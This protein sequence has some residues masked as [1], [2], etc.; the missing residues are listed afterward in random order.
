MYHVQQAV[1]SLGS[2]DSHNIIAP[3]GRK[4]FRGKGRCPLRSYRAEDGHSG[5]VGSTEVKSGMMGF[6]PRQSSTVRVIP[7]ELA[8]PDSEPLSR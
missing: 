4:A 8:A 7:L 6:A 5:L 2:P 3:H 1:Y